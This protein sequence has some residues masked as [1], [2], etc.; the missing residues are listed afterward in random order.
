MHESEEAVARTRDEEQGRGMLRRLVDRFRGDDIPGLS[1]EIAYRFLFAIFP[2][3]LFVAAL[4]AF[5]A[6]SL[7]IQNPAQLIVGALGDNLPG[8]IAETL[9]PELERLIS[10]PQAGVLSAGALAALWAGTSGTN[11]VVKGIHRAYG[12]PESRPLLVR[13]VIAIA[14]TIAGAFC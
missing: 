9:R 11:A 5:V 2:F 8:P 1:A 4:G 10:S 3:G 12:I 6:A 13:Y 7:D 14:L